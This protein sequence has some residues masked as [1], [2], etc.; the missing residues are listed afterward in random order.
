MNDEDK[1]VKITE[2]E[3]IDY[4]IEKFEDCIENQCS[5]DT[6]IRSA[7]QLKL[8]MD[9]YII[10]KIVNLYDAPDIIAFLKRTNTI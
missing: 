6:I 4:F 2:K 9:C 5:S 7:R 1:H 10:S 8:I 3:S